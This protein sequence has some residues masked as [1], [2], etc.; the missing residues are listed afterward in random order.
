MR[1]NLKTLLVMAPL[2][3]LL[4]C[5]QKQASREDVQP[6]L[7]KSIS[8]A[9]EAETFVRYIGQGRSTYYFASGHLHY[10]L[11]EVNR[12]VQELSNLDASEDLKNLLNVDRVQLR[13]L[14]VQIENARQ[15]LQQPN[16][17]AAS[18]QK[19]RGIRKTLV[20]AKSSL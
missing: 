8:L 16:V 14:A 6:D 7:S 3:L 4:A 5:G 9:S 15:H 13:L 17:L 2:I 11:D 18:V 19:I 10:L 20:Q 1:L 12:S